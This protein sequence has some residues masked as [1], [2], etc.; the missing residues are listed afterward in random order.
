[1]IQTKSAQARYAASDV[2]LSTPTSP[3]RF[4]D[5]VEQELEFDGGHPSDDFEFARGVVIAAAIGLVMWTVVFL[6]VML[7]FR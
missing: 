6:I 7:V 2:C 4:W 1:M 3:K 5:E